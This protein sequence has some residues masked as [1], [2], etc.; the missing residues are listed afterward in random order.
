MA[1]TS[2]WPSD[3]SRCSRAGGPYKAR[4]APTT[5]LGRRFETGTLPYELLA[6]FNATIDYLDSIGGLEAIR[7][8]ERELGERFLGSISDRVTVY[9]LQ[10]M[11]GREPTFL[12]GPGLPAALC[13][14]ARETAPRD[15]H[16][17]A[18]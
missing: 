7:P 12:I 15:R 5:P 18:N 6:G 9:G 13:R 11:E 16:G 2:A 1:P 4:P 3:A 8:Y 17:A 14:A 10:G